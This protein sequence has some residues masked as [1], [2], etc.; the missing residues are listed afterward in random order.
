MSIE[1]K[2]EAASEVH[3][4]VDRPGS[5]PTLTVD[6]GS[7]ADG[8]TSPA[9]AADPAG[10]YELLDEIARGGMGAVHR[11][12]DRTLGRE[13]AVKLLQERFPVGS[14]AARR[15]VD[16]ARIAGQLQHPGIAPVHDLGTLADGRPFLAMKLIKGRTLDELLR[17]RPDPA[18]DR[19]RSLAAFEQA[20]QAVAYAHSRRVIHRD[21]KPA[22][23]M[24]GAF[25]EVQ[26]MDWGLAKVLGDR[27]ESAP[28]HPPDSD[29]HLATEIRSGRDTDEGSETQAGSVL[30][31]PAFMAPEQAVGAVDQVDARSDVFGLGAILAVILTGKPPYVGADAEGTRVLAARGKLDD[32][33]A[34]LDASGADPELVALGK[35]CLSPERADRPADA[36]AVASAV[37]ALRAEA[38]ERARQAELDRVRA[39]GEKAAAEA[40]ARAQRQ[41]RRAQLAAAAGLLGLLVVGAGG[42]LAVRNQAQARRADAE[43]L[44]NVALGRAEQLVAQAAA[45]DPGEVRPAEEAVR[46]WEQA[47]AV[48]SQAAESAAGAD[49]TALSARVGGRA[50]EVRSGLARARHN[51]ALLAA[52]EVAASADQGTAGRS[53]DRRE[54]AR[55]YRAAF[56]AAGLPAADP[57][58]LAAAIR[59]EPPRLRAALIRAMDDWSLALTLAKDPGA[60]RLR[61]AL[62]LLDGDPLRRK[63]RATVATG[64]GAALVALAEAADLAGLSNQTIDLLC[65]SLN[66]AGSSVQVPERVFPLLRRLRA[67]DPG[68]LELLKVLSGLAESTSDPARIEEAIG[69]AWS[70]VAAH[71]DSAYGRYLL[72]FLHGSPRN[73]PAAAEPHYLKALELNPRFTFAMINLGRLRERVADLAGAERWYRRALETDPTLSRAHGNLGIVLEARGDWP[74]AEAVYREAVARFPGNAKLQESLARMTQRLALLPRLDAVRAGRDEPASPAEAVAFA[75]L[76]RTPTHRDALAAA[77]LYE[78][79]FAGDPT[80]ADDLAG[81]YRY[82]AAAF[83][84][85]AGCGLGTGAPADPSDRASLRGRA[86]MWLRADLALRD[87]QAASQDPARRRGAAGSLEYWLNDADLAGV[88]PGPGRIDLPAEERAAW[89][90]LW[91]DVRTTLDRARSASSPDP[92]PAPRAAPAPAP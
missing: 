67:E 57:E 21:L 14:L 79:A 2:R 10:R 87:E 61:A 33:F 73:D 68:N 55:R 31:T 54:S 34:R 22:N 5:P 80:L 56:E 13:V 24:V 17:G 76:L 29:E 30:G 46:L 72:G 37:A 84:A 44:A 19:G 74:A 92:S 27:P 40:E 65:R 89:D 70:A 39:E 81:A 50:E 66:L 69:C 16:E 18:A 47:E 35:R 49:D 23:V 51:A 71:P 90:A 3:P 38:E 8:P 82:G 15:F 32:C 77:R 11:A 36:G 88:R 7:G 60:E 48:V 12:V 42:W 75:D 45:I 6:S 53:L 41:R 1:P 62:G 20:C 78:R 9:G 85:R 83:A 58:A 63:I 64:D 86:L 26:V 28:P 25:G 52:L 91:A 43:R 4:T 59:A